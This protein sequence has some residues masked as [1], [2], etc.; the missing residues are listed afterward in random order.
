ML[1]LKVWKSE[2]LWNIKYKWGLQQGFEIHGSAAPRKKYRQQK[3][4]KNDDK[5]NPEKKEIGSQNALNMAKS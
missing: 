2:V 3:K 1:H 4:K 5:R